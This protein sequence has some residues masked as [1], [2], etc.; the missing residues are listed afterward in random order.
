MDVYTKEMGKLFEDLKASV[1]A[2]AAQ[3]IDFV[4]CRQQRATRSSGGSDPVGLT[5]LVIAMASPAKV[6]I[7]ARSA[8]TR[9]EVATAARW[10]RDNGA[11]C[12]MDWFPIRL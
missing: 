1:Q 3:V 6:S 8:T 10:V 7:I 12:R 5:K 2:S 9:N 4:G 11:V